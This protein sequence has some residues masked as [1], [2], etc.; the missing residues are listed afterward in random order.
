MPERTS[1]RIEETKETWWTARHAAS[2]SELS[3]KTWRTS[4]LSTR[5]DCKKQVRLW[6]PRSPDPD[7]RPERILERRAIDAPRGFD[8]E[9]ALGVDRA[10]PSAEIEG[11]AVAVGHTVGECYAAIYT[12]R[13]A[14]KN[15]EAS[16]GE[17]LAL[18]GDGVFPRIQRLGVED[19]VKP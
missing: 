18:F 9:L 19:R 5:E 1:W 12:T 15:A 8:T 13:A 14:G 2:Q 4:R 6:R 16:V 11:W 3:V 17:R 7:A 10:G